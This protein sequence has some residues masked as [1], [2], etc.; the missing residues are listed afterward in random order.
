MSGILGVDL[1]SADIET[2]KRVLLQHGVAL[3]DVIRE[4]RITGSGDA[5]IKGAVPS[6]IAAILAAAP[7]EAIFLN[8]NKAYE[9]FQRH[10]PDLLPIATC[11]PSTSPANAKW[12]LEMLTEKWL[13]ALSPH[14]GRDN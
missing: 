14:I 10:F 5:S 9:L 3:H 8:G 1:T 11:L 12:T 7:V 13:E 4:C 2:R 6:D